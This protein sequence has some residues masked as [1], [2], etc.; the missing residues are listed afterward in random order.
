MKKGFLKKKKENKK[1]FRQTIVHIKRLAQVE[2]LI[3]EDNSGSGVQLGSSFFLISTSPTLLNKYKDAVGLWQ[4]I[5]MSS[6]Q[7]M[8]QSEPTYTWHMHNYKNAKWITIEV[9]IGC[10]EAGT[11]S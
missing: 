10:S 6:S 7:E 8:K 4:L 1:M 5:G 11:T 9:H 3:R 2:K